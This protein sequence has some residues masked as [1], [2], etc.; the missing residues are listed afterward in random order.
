MLLNEG[1]ESAS[2]GKTNTKIKDTGIYKMFKA[3]R[4]K[5]LTNHHCDVPNI[6]SK[7]CNIEMISYS[8]E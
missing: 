1:S 6:S 4:T 5:E 3:L 7:A 2:K 8:Q